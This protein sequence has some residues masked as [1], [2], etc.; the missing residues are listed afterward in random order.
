[1]EEESYSIYDSNHNIIAE[2]MSLETACILL[3]GL[4]HQYYRE[5]NLSFSLE[6]EWKSK[7][8]SE[9]EWPE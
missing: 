3:K 9:K 2:N 1:M 5:E 8:F 6:R 4:M 7:I